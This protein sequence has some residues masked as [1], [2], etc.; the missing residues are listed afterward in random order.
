MYLHVDLL[1]EV[2]S[3]CFVFEIIVMMEESCRRDRRGIV[4]EERESI[5]T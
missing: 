4:S 5:D 1:L 3:S 2:V